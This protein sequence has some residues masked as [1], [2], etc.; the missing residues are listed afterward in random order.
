MRYFNTA[1]QIVMSIALMV[2]AAAG[3]VDVEAAKSFSR[4]GHPL[5]QTMGSKCHTEVQSRNRHYRYVKFQRGA[6]KPGV[7]LQTRARLQCEPSLVCR[8]DGMCFFQPG[9]LVRSIVARRVRGIETRLA[10]VDARSGKIYI[11]RQIFPTSVRGKLLLKLLK[12]GGGTRPNPSQSPPRAK[13]LASDGKQLSLG[14]GDYCWSRSTGPQTWVT[15]CA[16]A[17]APSSRFDLPL[18][19]AQ[20]E[21][22]LHIALAVQGP[23]AVHVFLLRGTSIEYSQALS[24]SPSV[25]WTLPSVTSGN[26][27][28]LVRGD[29]TLPGG[30]NDFVYYLARLHVMA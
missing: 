30:P 8:A 28:L 5:A 2:C 27:Y 26:Y 4:V 22:S 14:I 24:A 7:R 15:A 20:H 25:V 10:V 18:V 1:A 12:A 19:I 23:T 17:V 29:R 11:N 13:L 21:A 9:T 16:T 6:L 3:A